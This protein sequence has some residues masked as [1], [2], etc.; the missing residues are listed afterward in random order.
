[1]KLSLASLKVHL[2]H[3]AL[4]PDTSRRIGVLFTASGIP[5]LAAAPVRY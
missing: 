4:N 1:M 3:C 2:A 5:A